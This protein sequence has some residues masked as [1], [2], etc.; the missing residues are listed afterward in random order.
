VYASATDIGMACVQKI[1]TAP[2]EV[3]F[4]D[5]CFRISGEYNSK[6]R[7][8]NFYWEGVEAF[9]SKFLNPTLHPTASGMNYLTIAGLGFN[10]SMLNYLQLATGN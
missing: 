8:L 4:F 7:S 6:I 10:R 3:R 9:I 1:K 5:A 2:L